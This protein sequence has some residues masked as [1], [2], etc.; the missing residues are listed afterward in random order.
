M[1][2]LKTKDEID[3]MF[4]NG[5]V[6]SGILEGLKMM[7]RPDITTQELDEYAE[8]RIREAGA[9]PAFKG[10]RGYKATLCCSLNSEVVHGI[11][12]K[13]RKIKS[14]DIVSL[15]LGLKKN[16]LFSDM[17]VTIPVGVVSEQVTKFLELSE[18]ALMTGIMNAT[19]GKRL[20]DV[21]S[22]IQRFAEKHGFSVV[23]DYVGH[24]IGRKLHEDPVIPNFGNPGTGPRLEVGMVLAIEPMVNMGGY[25]VKVLDDGWTVVTADGSLS[26]HFE[27]SVA[28][29]D[30][31]PRVLTNCPIGFKKGDSFQI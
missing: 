25:Q 11:P 28:I 13:N 5:C 2:P 20:G 1:I 9:V 22:S 29:T 7:T 17:A 15:D 12:S 16:G 21:S 27:H 26:A 24:G 10:Y 3:V 23:R 14:G 8:A 31:G 18:K 19:P 4:E 30:S 6:L